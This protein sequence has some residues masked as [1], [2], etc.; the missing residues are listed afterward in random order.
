MPNCIHTHTY[1]HT[2]IILLISFK[3]SRR[4]YLQDYGY[5]W[6]KI[7]LNSE[8]MVLAKN[9]YL[10]G[11]RY[12]YEKSGKLL[13]KN[14]DKNLYLDDFWIIKGCLRKLEQIRSMT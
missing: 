11:H 14:T 12:K 4:K 5:L 7:I 3:L 2:K 1:S 9:V 6:G 13:L 8:L 10:R